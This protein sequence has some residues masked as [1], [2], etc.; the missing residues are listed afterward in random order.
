MAQATWYC[1]QC[2]K[3]AVAKLNG[4][5]YC[6]KHFDEAL[7][8]I[9]PKMKEEIESR[10]KKKA[11]AGSEDTA[12][13]RRLPGKSLKTDAPKPVQPKRQVQVESPESSG[14]SGTPE[15]APADIQ[16]RLF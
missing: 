16:E 1:K 2:G 8:K 13:N 14:V 5:A 15:P 10:Y 4:E 6:W 11:R 7:P 9:I 3:I 12:R